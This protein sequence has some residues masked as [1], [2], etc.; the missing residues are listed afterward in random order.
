LKKLLVS[1]IGGL[2]FDAGMQPLVIVVIKIVGDTALRIRQVGEK[3]ALA[4]FKDCTT[5]QK[6]DSL[7]GR[8]K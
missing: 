1:V 6:L 7:A 3:G 4:D 8:V 5:P 2:V